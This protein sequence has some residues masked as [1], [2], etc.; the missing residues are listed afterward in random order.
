VERVDDLAE[1]QLHT[2]QPGE[3][4]L[5]L[6][7]QGI[8]LV[9]LSGRSTSMPLSRYQSTLIGGGQTMLK[10]SQELRKNLAG[11]LISAEIRKNRTQFQ[12]LSVRS[13]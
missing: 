8:S 3:G 6:F 7:G 10:N 12:Q 11:K 1:D 13:K 5:A 9:K 2:C 4:S